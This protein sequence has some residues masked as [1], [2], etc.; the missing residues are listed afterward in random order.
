M[1]VASPLRVKF[2]SF[3]RRPQDLIL[4]PYMATAA[5][6][7][8]VPVTPAIGVRIVIDAHDGSALPTGQAAL[9]GDLHG[10]QVDLSQSLVVGVAVALTCSLPVQEVSRLYP[11]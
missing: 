11:T 8:N 5:H 4:I 3:V 9:Y 7:G 6:A 2:V 1:I 10:L